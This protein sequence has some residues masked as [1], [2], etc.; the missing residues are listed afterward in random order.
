MH[1]LA[2][3]YTVQPCTYTEEHLTG[4]PPLLPPPKKPFPR[5]H[6]RDAAS[7]GPCPQATSTGRCEVLHIHD[8][9]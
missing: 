3:A 8:G 9:A 1:Q 4:P 5:V 2:A 7:H 6:A